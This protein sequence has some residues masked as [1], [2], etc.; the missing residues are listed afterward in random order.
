VAEIAVE[1]DDRQQF[2]QPPARN[3]RL[4]DGSDVPMIDAV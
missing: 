3:P 2:S 1:L 4:V